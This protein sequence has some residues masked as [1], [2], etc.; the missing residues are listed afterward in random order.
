M[1]TSILPSSRAGLE[2]ETF[3]AGNGMCCQGGSTGFS[4]FVV[5]LT[6]ALMDSSLEVTGEGAAGKARRSRRLCG[7]SLA[8]G[9]L[10][11]LPWGP[12][13]TPPQLYKV[14]LGSGALRGTPPCSASHGWGVRLGSL[15][16]AKLQCWWV[17][18]DPGRAAG[19]LL[20]L[21]APALLRAPA[22]HQTPRGARR[23]PWLTPGPIHMLNI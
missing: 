4:V 11:S 19:T 23:S 7:G 16:F 12:W 1:S 10:P 20:L 13:L 8:G 6:K 22:G 17:P 9:T 2:A 14:Q 15:V 21:P 5:L 18:A 3:G